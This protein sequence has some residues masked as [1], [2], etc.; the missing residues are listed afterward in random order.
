MPENNLHNSSRKHL[1]RWNVT[2]SLYN[3]I[4]VWCWTLLLGRTRFDKADSEVPLLPQNNI[5]IATFLLIYCEGV[6]IALPS[7]QWVR[8]VYL[9]ILRSSQNHLPTSMQRARDVCWKG[10]SAAG[11]KS[12]SGTH[13]LSSVSC[14]R[15]QFDHVYLWILWWLVGLLSCTGRI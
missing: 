10:R 6:L 5:D 4:L 13:F 7:C 15:G 14:I 3:M 1:G 9:L 12:F 2:L 8:Q 11:L